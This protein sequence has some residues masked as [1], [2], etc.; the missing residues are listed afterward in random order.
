MG[1]ESV[2]AWVP[3]LMMIRDAFIGAEYTW[4]GTVYYTY[5]R[6]LT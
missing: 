6:S 3:D 4:N 2:N 5:E 1:L